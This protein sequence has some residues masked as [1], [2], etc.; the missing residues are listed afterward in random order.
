MDKRMRTVGTNAFDFLSDFT[1]ETLKLRDLRRRQFPAG[2]NRVGEGFHC[3][4]CLGGG[5]DMP[6]LMM[7]NQISGQKQHGTFGYTR[8][9][10]LRRRSPSTCLGS[11]SIPCDSMICH[12]R[13][14]CNRSGWRDFEVVMKGD[15]SA[16][17]TSS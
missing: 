9:Y 4:S 7:Q 3:T 13:I 16:C 17:G 14:G 5:R 12:P 1:K 6:V 2:K 11:D 8:S 10:S 15:S